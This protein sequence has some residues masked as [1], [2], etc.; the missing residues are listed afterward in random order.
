MFARALRRVE[1]RPGARVIRI[2]LFAVATAISARLSVLTPLSPVPLTMQVLVVLLSGLMLG[3]RDGLLAQIAYLQ[4]VLLGAPVTASGLAGPAAFVGPTAGYLIAFPLAALVAGW[5]GQH[6]AA[7]LAWRALG[8]IAGMAAIYAL[9]TA[10]LA[11][12]VGNLSQAVRLGVLPFVA[13]DALKAVIAVGL[14]STRK[15]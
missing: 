11:V 7:R 5:M 14:V 4:A 15:N 8:A 1:V 12:Y 6:S 10:W 3:P 2:A 9:G 13:V